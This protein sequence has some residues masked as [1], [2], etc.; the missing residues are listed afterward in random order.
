[1]K[2][3][4]SSASPNAGELLFSIE[5]FEMCGFQLKLSPT[6]ANGTKTVNLS[7][8]TGFLMNLSNQN[9]SE[10]SEVNEI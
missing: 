1:M 4:L 5:V 6:E 9:V 10:Y 3:S 7:K 8:T 2:F